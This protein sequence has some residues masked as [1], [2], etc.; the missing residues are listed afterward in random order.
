MNDA[1]SAIGLGAR[2]K[3]AR[4]LAQTEFRRPLMLEAGAG[5]GKTTTL[6][7]RALAWLLGPGWDEAAQAEQAAAQQ[8]DAAP[9]REI[10]IAA[11]ALDR[12][13]AITFTEAAAA[14][15]ENRIGEALATLVGGAAPMGMEFWW[16]RADAP[17]RERRAHRS[18]V[19]LDAFDH[20]RVSTIHSFCSQLLARHPFEAGLAPR[21]AIDD[22]QRLLPEAAREVVEQWLRAAQGTALDAPAAHLA[23]RGIGL[24]KLLEALITLAQEGAPPSALAEDPLS[25]A[26]LDALLDRLLAATHAL[27]AVVGERLA[28]A[29]RRGYA[30]LLPGALAGLRTALAAPASRPRDINALRGL[31]DEQLSPAGRKLAGTIGNWCRGKLS[32]AGERELLGGVQPLLARRAAALDQLLTHVARLDPQLLDSARRLLHPWLCATYERLRASGVQTYQ[33]LLDDTC[34]LLRDHPAV[35]AQIRARIRQ[36]LVDEFQDTDVVQCEIVRW[37]ALDGPEAERPGLFLVGDPKQSIYGWRRADLRAYDDFCAR[38]LGE[39]AQPERL[40]VNFRSAPAILAEVDRV[41]RGGELMREERGV[42]PRYVEVLAST[43]NQEQRPGTRLAVGDPSTPSHRIE[44]WVSWKPNAAGVP[45]PKSTRAADAAR[46]EAEAIAADI[47]TLQERLRGAALGAVARKATAEKPWGLDQVAIL[48]RSTSDLDAYLSALRKAGIPFAVE[49]DRSYYRRR[50][51]IDAAALLRA[52]LDPADQLAL[53]TLL[54]SPMVGVPDAALLPLWAGRLP[55]RLME[56]R[57]DDAVALREIDDLLQ[58]VARGLPPDSPGLRRIQGWETSALAALHHLA[59]LRRSF[60]ADDPDVFLE[61]VRQTFL[62]EATEATRYLAPYRIANLDRFFRVLA[63]AVDEA[64]SDV[65]ALLRALRQSVAQ[66]RDAEEGRPPAAL[67]D[68]VRIMT[69]HKAKGLEFEHVYLA[70]LHKQHGRGEHAPASAAVI[71]GRWEYSL[72]GAPTLGYDQVQARA[73]DVEG[74][75][76]VRTLYV[77]MTR[78]KE[79]LVLLGNWPLPAQ[80]V[81]AGQ[82]QTLLELLH[83]RPGLP[84]LA[85]LAAACAQ[86]APVQIHADAA[87]AGWRFAHTLQ[88]PIPRTDAAQEPAGLPT[89]EQLDLSSRD[90]HAARAAARVRMAR[91]FHGAASQQ[92]HEALRELRY[93]DG[94]PGMTLDE[95]SAGTART[96]A[97]QAHLAGARAEA[98]QRI[99][100]AVG[101]AL[102]RVLEELDLQQAAQTGADQVQT[103]VE[104]VLAALLDEPLRAQARARAAQLLA[105]VT[106][107]GLLQHLFALRDQVVAR[108]LPVLLSPRRDDGPVGFL[109]GT[110]DLLYI[111]PQSGELVV[112]DYKTDAVADDADLHERARAYCLQGAVYAQ[113]VQEALGLPAAPRL[114]LWFL[115]ADRIWREDAA[116]GPLA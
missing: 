16:E 101:S 23:A 17:E 115:A 28:G 44:Y 67:A 26:R 69:I 94:P 90:L 95:D 84:P 104:V 49:R 43:R 48:L 56:L 8:H 66:E 35:R 114:E 64:G 109:S 75:E 77:A 70:Q 71:A 2:D 83:S 85:A 36:L 50:E 22:E 106:A 72:L 20:L 63:G 102:H 3:Q 91:P 6:V 18:H 108:E 92:A 93:E 82:A 37:I 34:A 15:M 51:I 54:R 59:L 46:I 5:T 96:V 110:I 12:L 111:D 112:A 25:P 78:A 98:E 7:S 80:P 27:L 74:A 57:P 19:L 24:D 79:R 21:F 4:W 107:G 65:Q 14:E 61:R 62:Q 45:D 116:A 113:A 32:S 55:E 38:V 97:S 52:V 89:A 68:A 11:F 58:G 100:M 39:R 10:Q 1:A 86:G 29:P 99:A 40:A 30:H 33:A 13:V 42:Q 103:R 60:R 53:V 31:I 73:R 76:R 41:I 9:A 87:D 81:D 105:R 88:L 47:L